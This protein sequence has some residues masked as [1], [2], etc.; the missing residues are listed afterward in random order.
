MT[1]EKLVQK[2]KE[3]LKTDIDLSFLL[4]LKKEEI[5]TLVACIRDRT[6]QK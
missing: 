6:D 1:K 2:I 4:E 3:L 5:E